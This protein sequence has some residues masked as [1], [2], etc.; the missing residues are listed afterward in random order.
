MMSRKID[1]PSRDQVQDLDWMILLLPF[2]QCALGKFCI[3]FLWCLRSFLLRIYDDLEK[4]AR[5]MEMLV[6]WETSLWRNSFAGI[7]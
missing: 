6:R 1:A 3:Q 7:Q 4:E 5:W 2:P